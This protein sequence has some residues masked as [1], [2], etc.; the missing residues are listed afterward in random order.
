MSQDATSARPS[1]RPRD[2]GKSDG[3]EEQLVEVEEKS[4][5]EELKEKAKS[6]K[7]SVKPG[8]ILDAL[9]TAMTNGEMTR[10]LEKK[11]AGYLRETEELKA[12]VKELEKESES[13]KKRVM[14]MELKDMRKNIII[15][16]LPLHSK[17]EKE[18][19]P[20]TNKQTI[21]QVW[22]VVKE[23]KIQDKIA[24]ESVK[25]FRMANG[26]AG[27][28]QVRFERPSQKAAFFKA[29]PT[30]KNK[31]KIFVRDEYPSSIMPMVKKAEA[32]AKKIYEDSG[33]TTKTRIQVTGNGQ[34]ILKAKKK[35]ETTF[36]EIQL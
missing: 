21:D 25:R 30:L 3:E 29:L 31:M 24:L 28:V 13:L 5:L 34:V 33:K 2:D 32:D 35:E 4:A 17:A 20:E 19:K 1:K 27:I 26:K 22:N 10:H 36:S 23:M 18:Q 16:N 12:R 11:L 6:R 15:S 8:D 7:Q 14:E 9:M